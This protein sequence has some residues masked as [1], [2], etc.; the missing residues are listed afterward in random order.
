[1]TNWADNAVDMMFRRAKDCSE[2]SGWRGCRVELDLSNTEIR[3]AFMRLAK[4]IEDIW[5]FQYRGSLY[6]CGYGENG[7]LHIVY[8]GEVAEVV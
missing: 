3:N 6:E 5:V 8:V 7:T 4:R 1:M 2:G